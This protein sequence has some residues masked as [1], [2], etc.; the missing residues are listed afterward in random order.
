MQTKLVSHKQIEATRFDA[1]DHDGTKADEAISW[2]MLFERWALTGRRRDTTV[3]DYRKVLDAF[4]RSVGGAPLETIQRRDLLAFRDALA[5]AGQSLT[6]VNRKLGIMKTLFRVALD[7]EWVSHNPA[8]GVKAA[9]RRESKARVAFSV[10]DLQR[11]F[12]SD[13]Y[14]ADYR[15]LG[16]GREAAFWLP[17]MALFTGARIEELAQLLVSDV[18]FEPGLGYY[19]NIS[20]EAAHS[21]LKNAASRRRIPLHSTLLD[22]GFVDYLELVRGGGFL[23]PHLKANPRDKRGGYFSNFFSG[24]L[25]KRV[26]ITDPRKVFHSF[27]HTFKDVCRAVG[28]DEAVHDALT[29]HTAPG[30]GRKYGNEQYPLPPLFDAIERYEIAGLDLS[31]LLKSRP[32]L[33]IRRSDT[34]LVSTFYGILVGMPRSLPRQR[35][36]P[37]IHARYQDHEAVIGVNDAR[38]L[39]GGLPE[40]KRVLVQA[41][42]EIH[43]EELLANWDNARATGDFFRIEP[44]R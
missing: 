25:R 20:D 34:S 32:A 31:S 13:I 41:W 7:Y 35:S 12:E 10:D 9:G 29:G 33:R 6:T 36:A 11:F 27:R 5:A 1:I 28:I 19:L 26:G 39:T 30:A 15:P 3:S 2:A 22:C 43:R 18:H 37:C 23:F 21:K 40:P 42:L 4:V 14:T 38:L 8:D 24:Y 17:L 16:G 44:L